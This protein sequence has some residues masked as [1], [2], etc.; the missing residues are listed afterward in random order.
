MTLAVP[1]CCALLLPGFIPMTNQHRR[2]LAHGLRIPTAPA[3]VMVFT[4]E[5]GELLLNC[6]VNGKRVLVP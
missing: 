6:G 5:G 3:G 2:Q 4:S 1:R